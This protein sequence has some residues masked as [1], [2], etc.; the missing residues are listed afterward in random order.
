MAARR[1][2]AGRRGAPSAELAEDELARHWSLSPE[3]LIEFRR[4]ERS[5]PSRARRRQTRS[6]ASAARRPPG[7]AHGDH[8]LIVQLDHPVRAG[9]CVLPPDSRRPGRRA[10]GWRSAADRRIVTPTQLTELAHDTRVD[11]VK[12]DAAAEEELVDQPQAYKIALDSR[13]L[14]ALGMV[15][16]PE[17]AGAGIAPGDLEQQ[18]DRIAQGRR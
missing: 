16:E 9:S 15:L 17:Q 2:R 6:C 18:A 4:A 3:D 13:G 7:A 11:V 12:A 14:G 1:R 10:W 8:E 5:R